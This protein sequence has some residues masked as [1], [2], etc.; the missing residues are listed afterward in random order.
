M[1]SCLIR[2][3]ISELILN[4]YQVRTERRRIIKEAVFKNGFR[5]PVGC[6]MEQFDQ[7]APPGLR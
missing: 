2:P 1:F 5:F 7:A 4:L 3:M 6:D